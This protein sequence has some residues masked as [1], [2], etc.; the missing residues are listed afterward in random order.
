MC[1]PLRE[2]GGLY[3]THMRN[4]AE[5][6]MDSLDESFRIA[7]E[8]GVP[9]VISHHKVN[10]VANHGR[11]RETL[12]FIAEHM[13]DQPIGLDCYPY[14]ASSTVLSATRV[15]V[16]SRVLVTWSKPCPQYA[17][18]ELTE[19]AAK[20]GVSQD[21]AV[22]RLLPAERSI[23]PWTKMTSSASSPSSHTMIGSTGCPT[24]R[25]RIRGYG[26]HSA[27]AGPLQPDA[28]AVPLELAVHKMTGLTRADVRARRPRGVLAPGNHADITIFDANSVDE[29][30]PSSSRL[31]PRGIDTVIVNGSVV[32]REG[33]V[34]RGTGG[35]RSVPYQTAH[36]TAQHSLP[37][38][39]ADAGVA[40]ASMT[41]E[42]AEFHV[43]LDREQPGRSSMSTFFLRENSSTIETKVTSY[44]RYRIPDV[45][46]RA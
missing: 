32:P 2:F 18:M 24:T 3:C 21:E 12:A 36:L 8:I 29:P 35:T 28:G 26:R 5:A 46:W 44:P 43:D 7:R 37:V 45:L 23:S 10:G 41:V 25:F 11:S 14:T 39:F 22:A 6:V 31:R 40:S 33:R 34:D 13:H 16:A 42:G 1:R 9:V 4:E 38:C 15:S 20:M 19:I 30:R 27:R 17:G